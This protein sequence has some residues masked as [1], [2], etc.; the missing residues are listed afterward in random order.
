MLLFITKCVI[1][2][3][4]KTILQILL[5]NISN[6]YISYCCSLNVQIIKWKMLLFHYNDQKLKILKCYNIKFVIQG[7]RVFI[8]NEYSIFRQFTFTKPLWV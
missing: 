5:K 2:H 7:L 1:G 8:I 4:L 3:K 6:N